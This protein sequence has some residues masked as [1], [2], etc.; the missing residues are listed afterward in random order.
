MRL[1]GGPAPP[2]AD[3]AAA[4]LQATRRLI[5]LLVVPVLALLGVLTAQQY[6]ERLEDA[7]R[8]L[9]RRADE[10]AQELEALAR[11]ASAH[12]D[13]LH[14]LLRAQW[15]SPPDPGP[16]LQRALAEHRVEGRPDGW[17]L[18]E[19]DEATRARF[20]QFWFERAEG[21]APDEIWLRRAALFNELARVVHQRS[22]GFAATWFAAA[23]A[24]TSFG[25]PW[26]STASML[27]AMGA[28]TLREIDGPRQRGVERAYAE[29]KRPSELSFWGA[30]YVSQLDGQLVLSH[31]KM[32]V[33]DGVYLGE[34]SVDFR[35]APLQRRVQEWRRLG[36][37]WIVDSRGHVLADSLQPLEAP[38]GTGLADVRVQALL[39]ARLPAPLR[40]SAALASARP[41]QVLWVD[42]WVMAT[43]ARPGAPW[44]FV[45]AVPQA[46]LRAL[47]LPT[48]L[49][50]ALLGS[51]LLVVFVA[52]QWL[53][54]RRFVSPALEVL[55][56][57]RRAAHDADAPVPPLAG[58]WRVW[59]D[60]V[61]EIFRQQRESQR[62]ER[63]TEAF[64]SAI[65]DNAVTAIVTT[66]RDGRIVE[67]NPMAE[68]LYRCPRTQVLGKVLGDVLI[69]ER[70]RPAHRAEMDR[71]RAGERIGGIERP[72]EMIGL[73]ADGSEF[74]LEMLVVRIE[75]DGQIFY[76][77]F[78]TDLSEKREAARQIE[79]QR[80]ALRQS[81][82]LSAMGGLLAGVAHELNNPLAI[83]MGRAS[84]LEERTQDSAAADDARRIREAAERC[85]RIVRTFLNMA[86]QRPAVRAP[87]QLNHLV[88]A[89]ADMLG[90]TLRS[91]GIELVL[92]LAEPLPEV[93]ADADQIGQVLLNLIV[94]A[95][96]ALA[97]VAGPRR[98][99]VQTGA[100]HL[101]AQES[102]WLR[103]ADSGPGVPASA[104]EQIFEPFF[105]TKAEGMGTG[106]GLAVSRS[107]A[108]EHG[109]DLVVEEGAE[110]GSF[111]LSLPVSA[112][113]SAAVAP[114]PPAVQD[115]DGSSAGRVLVVDDEHEIADMVRSMLEA[116]HYEVAV[117]E[118]GAVALELLGEARF[119]AIVS[120]LRMPDMDGAALW[121]EVRERDAALAGRMLFV[122]GDT[123]SPSARSFLDQAACGSLEKPFHPDELL[124]RVRALLQPATP[125]GAP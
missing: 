106:L 4:T 51:A 86:R 87:V 91:H 77:G 63:R 39:E 89:A 104:R 49:P 78:M 75:Q 108:R 67:F 72:T 65:V 70:H 121:R 115:D 2:V 8:D 99:V 19:A 31:G 123:L 98:V 116:A 1:P 52:G 36:R 113:A 62:R 79:R 12:V 28:T 13:D 21:G 117:A 90:Y 37:S 3:P 54:A 61:S 111:R 100:E 110:G 74:P 95:Q 119:D 11:P 92:Q 103:V 10:H 53:L 46:E 96:Q 22:P 24:N 76:T 107:L 5:W 14:E 15:R 20:G 35:L 73:C 40:G 58:R 44:T 69:P 122:T 23:E 33:D 6:R 101:G 59:V 82:K 32:L 50:N 18:D 60:A 55:D 45:N 16:A 27:K 85:G 112:A 66:D 84:L 93:Q 118:S 68:R 41:G 26:S 7:G 120:D 64:K 42:G 80:D 88:R 114:A 71:L 124:A 57:L 125:Q 81:E 25:Y 34:V 102:V 30:P 83:V 48:L 47:V 43:A 9:Q 56:Y 97:G 94:N 105:T 17:S 29:L 38:R 109:G